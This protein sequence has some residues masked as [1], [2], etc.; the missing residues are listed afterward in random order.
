M[1]REQRLSWSVQ[2]AVLVGMLLVLMGYNTRFEF[3][4]WHFGARDFI[5][6]WSVPRAL[7]LDQGMYDRAWH[8]PLHIALGFPGFSAAGASFD[9]LPLW[10]PPPIVLLLLPFGALPFTA[11]ALGWTALNLGSFGHAILLFNRSMDHPLPPPLGLWIALF[12]V[13]SFHAARWGQPT[14]FLVACLIYTWNAQRHGKGVAAGLLLIPLLLKPHLFIATI[15]LIMVA[16]FRRRNFRLTLALVGGVVILTTMLYIVEPDWYQGWRSQ[17]LSNALTL[18]LSDIIVNWAGLPESAQLLAFPIGGLVAIVR[19]R[20]ASWIVPARLGEAT[21]LSALF[22]PYLWPHDLILLT[23]AAL[24]MAGRL[25]SRGWRLP[26]T[27]P[28]ILWWL[29][30][31]EPAL[32]T[33]ALERVMV[34]SDATRASL[35]LTPERQLLYRILLALILYLFFWWR[36]VLSDP[37]RRSVK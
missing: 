36:L 5:A 9:Y 8:Q 33:N 16:S 29:P 19:Y 35:T 6:Y 7:I 18:S 3:N 15:T 21:I 13:P 20:H 27:L 10:N 1:R 4:W 23:P 25:W 12:F 17:G 22:S 11:A 34:L 31:L 37:P 26:L 14:P 30:A 32:L 24:V 2:W 28:A